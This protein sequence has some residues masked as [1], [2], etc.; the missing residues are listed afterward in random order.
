MNRSRQPKPISQL[1]KKSSSLYDL[2]LFTKLDSLL[3]SFL[4]QHNIKGCRVGN[5]KNGSLLIEIP[6]ANWMMRLQFMRND[7]LS[8]LRQA[9]PGLL[10]INIKV[11]PHLSVNKKN[12]RTTKTRK[13]IRASK[14]PTDVAESFLALAEEA[15]PELKKA[16]Q[17]LAEYSKK[18]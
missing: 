12:I 13:K 7:L 3:Q 17:S 18:G 9:S 4:K 11:N 1:L 2:P 14:M 6:N 5:L 15:D 10:K 8:H 16:L